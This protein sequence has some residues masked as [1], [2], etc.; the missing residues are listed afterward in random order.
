MASDKPMQKETPPKLPSKLM[1][2]RDCATEIGYHYKALRNLIDR[3]KVPYYKVGRAVKLDPAEV[4]AH[5]GQHRVEPPKVDS[6][7]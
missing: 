1:T 7:G 3:Q 5:L 2:V 6:N 4:L